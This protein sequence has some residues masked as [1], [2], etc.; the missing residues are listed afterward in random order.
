MGGKEVEAAIKLLKFSMRLV[1][2]RYY[3]LVEVVEARTRGR[4]P[5]KNGIPASVQC[6]RTARPLWSHL[7]WLP[8]NF[9]MDLGWDPRSVEYISTVNSF[10][11]RSYIRDL[12]GDKVGRFLEFGVNIR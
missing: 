5:G 6:T 7:E 2:S 10:D 11:N 8:A 4:I 12:G 3:R 1:L 9:R